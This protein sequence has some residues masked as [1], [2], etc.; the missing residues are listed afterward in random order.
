MG[1]QLSRLNIAIYAARRLSTDE[2]PQSKACKFELVREQ[3]TG[4]LE[5]AGELSMYATLQT[6]EYILGSLL[7]NHHSRQY[8]KPP[9]HLRKGARIHDS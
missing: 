6:R 8:R 1:S 2:Q 9:R 7:A 5:C 3:F 4:C